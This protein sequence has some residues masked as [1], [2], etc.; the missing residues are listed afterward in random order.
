[1]NGIAFIVR[2]RGGWIPPIEVNE[3]IHPEFVPPAPPAAGQTLTAEHHEFIVDMAGIMTIAEL[4]A[5]LG[6]GRGVVNN[7]QLGRK[8]AGLT[9][10]SHGSGTA[11]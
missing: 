5:Y 1:M 4:A 2:D 8:N 6:V 9:V 11:S 10:V 7:I 3:R